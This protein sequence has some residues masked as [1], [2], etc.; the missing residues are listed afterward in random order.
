MNERLR[1]LNKKDYITHERRMQKSASG[2]KEEENNYKREE[3]E[4]RE[5]EESV[6]KEREKVMKLKCQDKL[7]ERKE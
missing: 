1:K 5:E 3:C 6:I 4:R 2:S 7:R